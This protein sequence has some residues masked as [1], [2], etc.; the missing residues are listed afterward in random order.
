[1][2]TLHQ[3]IVLAEQLKQA[4]DDLPSLSHEA[5]AQLWKKLRLEWNYNSNHIE[6]N[7][8]TYAETEVLLMFDR[9][10]GDHTLQEYEE[11]RAHDVAI[12]LVREWA[13]DTTRV[14][15]EADIRALNQTILVRPFW[16]E[17]MT[18]NG[19]STRRLIE[20]GVY[21][22]HP[23]SV[24]TKTGEIF[25]YASPD[26]TPRLMAELMDWYRTETH[27]LPVASIAAEFHYRF[28]RIHPFDDGN[29]RVARLLVNYLLLRHGYLP[30]VIK[31]EEKD[32]YLAAL[33]K[34][35]AGDVLAFHVYIAEQMAWPLRLAVKAARGE[36]LDE[37]G[38]SAKRLELLK[39]RLKAAEN[40]E[41]IQVPFSAEVVTDMANGWFRQIVEQVRSQ[42]VGFEELFLETEAGVWIS[43][44]RAVNKTLGVILTPAGDTL[45]ISDLFEDQGRI[46]SHDTRFSSSF[47][48]SNLKASGIKAITINASI[49]VEFT[50]I[51][52]TLSYPVFDSAGDNPSKKS[53]KIER[54]FHQGI[55]EPEQVQIAEEIAQAVLDEI[56]YRLAH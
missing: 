8:L 29:G 4:L 7:T 40:E 52:Y 15:T 30:I 36:R 56:D 26:E 55:T 33:Q 18:P 48:L 21:K 10:S 38:D 50:D 35:D 24:R 12:A 20:V 53:K 39:R 51:K 45:T 5:S 31:S 34:A 22:R 3:H 47:R 43:R 28:I 13:A 1:M 16:K 49:S 23:N 37:P 54:L 27:G 11:M 41:A 19:Q 17:A 2:D 32:K 46:S 25:S 6:G 9:T 14:L 42:L 44:F